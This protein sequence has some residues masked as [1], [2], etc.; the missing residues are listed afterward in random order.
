MYY[1]IQKDAGKLWRYQLGKVEPD[2]LEANMVH[3]IATDMRIV[4]YVT[5]A[6]MFVA[7]DTVT[8]Q[9]IAEFP[10]RWNFGMTTFMGLDGED[11]IM[12]KNSG[13]TR[14]NTMGRQRTSAPIDVDAQRTGLSHDK[15]L[16]RT[17]RLLRVK[18]RELLVNIDQLPQVLLDLVNSF[19]F[20]FAEEAK[21]YAKRVEMCSKRAKNP[22]KFIEK[23]TILP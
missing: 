13:F 5:Q 14:M 17:F 16:F 12:R 21:A 4:C 20:P 3:R 10:R 22:T 8:E 19:L 23:Y 15:D 6:H 9:T 7:V 18:S 2:K 1:F 11:L